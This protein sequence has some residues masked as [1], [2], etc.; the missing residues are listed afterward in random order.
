[1]IYT[2]QMRSALQS[3]KPPHDFVIDIVEY[4]LDPKMRF[5]AI[6]FYE[7]QWNYYTEKEM[8]DCVAYLAK[9]RK[10]ITSFG[11]KVTLEP[12]IDTGDT[13]P[14]RLKTRANGLKK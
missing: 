13:I 8:L 5:L 11:A 6:R 10:I 14:E 7:S 4:D 12:V 9:V 2:H 1:M 3:I